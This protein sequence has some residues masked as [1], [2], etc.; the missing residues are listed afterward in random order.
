VILKAFAGRAQDWIDV[1][2][3]IVRQG[4][5]LDRRLVL[6][7]LRPLLE[8]KEDATAEPRLLEL[9]EK[10]RDWT[11]WPGPGDSSI[12]C[13]A[14]AARRG[15]NNARR[16]RRIRGRNPAEPVPN[17]PRARQH[18]DRASAAPLGYQHRMDQHG[19]L[20]TH[21]EQISASM[22]YTPR[23]LFR[24]L[25]DTRNGKVV[26]GMTRRLTTSGTK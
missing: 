4:A 26:H 3:I 21:V 24:L 15:P 25:E 11:L 19:T 14:R 1:E 16:N 5:A 7:D 6:A 10:H 8:L 17:R 22:S 13:K 20:P 9:F 2:G 12:S 23:S 18:G